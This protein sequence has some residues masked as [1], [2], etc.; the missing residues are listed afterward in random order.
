MAIRHVGTLGY[1]PSVLSKLPGAVAEAGSKLTTAL[2]TVRQEEIKQEDKDRTYLR[3]ALQNLADKPKDQ[4]DLFLQGPGGKELEKQTKRVFGKSV[5]EVLPPSTAN[6]IAQMVDAQVAAAKRAA[7][8]AGSYEALTP[9]QKFALR[10]D[11]YED[12]VGEALALLIRNPIYQAL[13]L[14][15]SP[16]S[17]KRRHMM[18]SNVMRSLGT[19]RGRGLSEEGA[20]TGALREKPLGKKTRG[21]RFLENITP[22]AIKGEK[23]PGVRGGG[24][25]YTGALGPT[26]KQAPTHLRPKEP[27]YAP[28]K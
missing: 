23:I 22:W 1:R 10:L 8:E 14:D 25:P 13:L 20:Y 5:A 3:T 26:G 19:Q 12:E 6:Q 28:E 21:R 27:W 15:D 4:Q 17:I 9:Q 16:E 2:A 7:I 18:E 11:G 24:S